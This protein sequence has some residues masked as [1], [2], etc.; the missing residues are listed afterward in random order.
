[1]FKIQDMEDL[2]QSNICF[3]SSSFEMHTSSLSYKYTCNAI[4]FITWAVD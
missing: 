1:M 4:F 2:F 3:M